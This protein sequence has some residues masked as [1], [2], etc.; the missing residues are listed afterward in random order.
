MHKIIKIDIK[1]GQ[2]SYGQRIEL[3]SVLA[4]ES[5]TPYKRFKQV[6]LILHPD[7]AIDLN[8]I[9]KNELAML[10]SYFEEIVEGVRY[11]MKREG[12]EL[13]GE[14]TSEEKQAGYPQMA[15]AI[16]VMG[17]VKSLASRYAQDPDNILKWKYGKVFNLLLTDLLQA[18]AA[19]KYRN[20]QAKKTKSKR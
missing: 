7:H 3:G 2:M 13:K 18:K 16:G 4:K 15:K 9:K 5:I 10:S 19:E 11:W 14:Y 8:T 20:I 17:S 1:G 12:E 6:I